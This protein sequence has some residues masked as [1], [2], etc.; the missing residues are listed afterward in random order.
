MAS[1][2]YLTCRRPT[3]GRTQG[4]SEGTVSGTMMYPAGYGNPILLLP[5]DA[6]ATSL[7]PWIA[8]VQ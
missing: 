3:R 1:Y 2:G 8:K 6:S 4:W 7:P 5:G